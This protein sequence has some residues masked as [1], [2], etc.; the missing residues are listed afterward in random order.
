[1][2]QA[3]PLQHL[4]PSEKDNLLSWG[5]LFGSSASLAISQL[6]SKSQ[7]LL[8]LITPDT[9][10]AD[11]L[12]NEIQ[13]FSKN[14]I[15]PIIHFSDW[16][17]LPYD[18]FSPHQ[19]IVSERLLTLY[20]LK[21]LQK[22]IVIVSLPTLMHRLL[23]RDYLHANVF[24]LTIGETLDLSNLHHELIHAGYRVVG[25]LLEH[26]EFAQRGAIIDIYPMGSK[27][28]YRIELL[29]NQVDSIRSFDAETQRSIEKVNSIQLLPAR[30]YPLTE[31]AITHFRQT[32]R[33][34]FSGNPA[35]APL[36]QQISQGEAAPGIEYY[37]PL[38]FD[39]TDSFIDYVNK[40]VHL[41]QIG[42]LNASAAKFWEEIK[43][44]YEQLRH[45]TTR[46]LCSPN[47]LF[48]SP[49]EIFHLFKPFTQIKIQWDR[50]SEKPGHINFSTIS[51][52]PLFVDHKAFEPLGALK[53]YVDTFL[54]DPKARLLFCA[55]STGRREILLSQLSEINRNPP[56][57]KTWQ[58]F[59][60]STQQMGITTGTIDQGLLLTD[61][62]LA[63]ITESQLF[64][65]QV[66]QRRLRKQKKQ[67]PALMIRNLTELHIGDPVV[68]INH[69]VGRYLGLQTIKT[70]DQEAEYLTLQYADN[71]KIYVPVSSL[72]LVSRYVGADADHAPLQKLGTKQWEKVKEKTAARIR[73]IAAELLDIYSRREATLGHAFKPPTHDFQKFRSEFPFEETPDQRTAI[74]DVIQNMTAKQS[75]DRLICGDVGFGKTEVAMQAAFS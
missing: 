37:L 25:Q 29:D 52:K 23:P 45:D 31:E 60:I 14:L 12:K 40:S 67:D 65:E 20:R 55:E 38:F 47:E 39:Q 63:L 4:T 26:G 11:Q 2:P 16:E 8:L 75:M 48:F 28:P 32:W 54:T 49:E 61:P 44:R 5:N 59:L 21:H 68:H 27:L 6:A 41:L 73:D 13:F 43:H 58:D 57:F 10:F 33:T 72:G 66:S 35:E 34:K 24:A 42:D 50:L 3:N 71:D 74:D 69:G 1:M 19:D 46:P 53:N 56:V 7:T 70:G 9:H 22:G 15:D 64:G 18:H 51:P 17:T 30:E 36:Y 62:P